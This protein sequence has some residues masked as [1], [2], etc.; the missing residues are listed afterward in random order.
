[1]RED[2]FLLNPFPSIGDDSGGINASSLP[3]CSLTFVGFQTL[4]RNLA[5]E[6]DG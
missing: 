4:A 1:L 6:P 5:H 2:P 3:S